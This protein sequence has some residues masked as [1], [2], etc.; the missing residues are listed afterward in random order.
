MLLPSVNIYCLKLKD[1]NY[2][3]NGMNMNIFV[4]NA[5]S[6]VTVKRYE[7]PHILCNTVNNLIPYNFFKVLNML[8][9]V[10]L[11]KEYVLDQQ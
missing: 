7:Y 9:C 3:M 10:R 1:K 8:L 11:S 6:L 4:G 2:A 5:M